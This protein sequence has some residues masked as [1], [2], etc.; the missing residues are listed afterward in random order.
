MLGALAGMVGMGAAGSLGTLF[1]KLT[2]DSTALVKGM[3]E[4]EGAVV[5]SAG[6]IAK[7]VAGIGLAIGAAM[8]A[9]GVIAVKEA[10]K[11]EE[12]M[13]KATAIMGKLSTTQRLGLEATARQMATTS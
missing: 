12:S 3:N 1:V 5:R 4:A 11:F 8:T 9:I 10:A 6:V 2:A 13:T 7:G